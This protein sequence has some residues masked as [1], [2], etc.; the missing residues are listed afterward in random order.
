M[1][2]QYLLLL[3]ASF[4]KMLSNRLLNF[5]KCYRHD[6]LPRIKNVEREWYT[7]IHTIYIDSDNTTLLF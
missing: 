1:Q 6:T 3:R 7:E 2:R 4:V 5:I